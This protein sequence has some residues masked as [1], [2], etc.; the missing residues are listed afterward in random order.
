[1]TNLAA[2]SAIAIATTIFMNAAS[3]AAAE[4]APR[5]TGTSD[6]VL[7]SLHDAMDANQ[8]QIFKIVLNTAE[9]RT[10]AKLAKIENF[11]APKA[12]AENALKAVAL[13]H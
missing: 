6:F 7:A 5:H 4:V 10:Q 1:M 3:P 11:N 8:A 12:H 2:K 13:T 9:R